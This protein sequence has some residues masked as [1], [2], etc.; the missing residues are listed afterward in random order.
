M[1]H[2]LAQRL[3]RL[4]QELG[5][6]LADV[7]MRCPVKAVPAD[8]P[9]RGHVSVDGVGSGGWRQIVKERGVEYGYVGKVRQDAPGDLDA[10]Q[11]GRVVQRRQRRERLER[12]DQVVV[13]DAGPVQVGSAVDH[14]VPDRDEAHLGGL[15]PLV[16]EC[17]EGCPQGRLVVGHR[18][19]PDALDD[20]VDHQSARI[21]FYDSIF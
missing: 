16:G 1:K 4:L 7:L 5:G 10:E 14:P 19:L 20:S 2:D 12:R 8:V 6:L 11:C 15:V 3:Q 9:L 21:R 17:V 13:D 18:A